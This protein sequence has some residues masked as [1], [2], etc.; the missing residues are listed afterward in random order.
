MRQEDTT[1]IAQ[2]YASSAAP[3]LHMPDSL[4]LTASF[5]PLTSFAQRL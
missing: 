2:I 5:S 3:T 1:C 4:Q